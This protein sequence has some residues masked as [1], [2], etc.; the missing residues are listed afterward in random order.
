MCLP[1]VEMIY[2]SGGI[3]WK[4]MMGSLVEGV[5]TILFRLRKFLWLNVP[6]ISVLRGILTLHLKGGG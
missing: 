5:E 3:D 1:R 6:R 4:I 2:V